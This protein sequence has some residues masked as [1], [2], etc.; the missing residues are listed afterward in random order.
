MT[1]VE[2]ERMVVRLVGDGSSYQKMIDEAINSTKDANRIMGENL[3][4]MQ[5]SLNSLGN[6]VGNIAGQFK[7]FQMLQS[8]FSFVREGVGLAADAEKNAAAFG[9]MFQSME[10]GLK[11]QSEITKFAAETPLNTAGIQ[12]AA[13]MLLQFNAATEDTVIPTLRMLGDVAGGDQQRL[14]GLAL[15]YGQASSTGRLMGQDLLQ[16][17]N[18]GFNPLQE[19]SR[20]TGKS[21]A[22]LKEDMEKGRITVDMLRNAFKT[23]TSE[24]GRFK[25]GMKEASK[26][27]DG[28]VSTMGD[29]L[30]GLKRTVGAFIIESFHLK[31]GIKMVS[32]E[33]Q[34]LTNWFNHLNPVVKEAGVIAGVAALSVGSLV[35]AW[36]IGAA[37]MAMSVGTFQ[38]VKAGIWGV[39]DGVKWLT[40]VMRGQT[41][42]QVQA[43]AGLAEMAGVQYNASAAMAQATTRAR[44]LNG[45]MIGL[46]GTLIALAAYAVIK[47]ASITPMEQR[48]VREM[49]EQLERVRKSMAGMNA[50]YA[51]DRAGAMSDLND[52]K[53]P[54]ERK[55]KLEEMIATGESNINSGR[56]EQDF[57]QNKVNEYRDSIMSSLSSLVPVET[58]WENE[59]KQWEERL[60]GSQQYIDDETEHVRKLKE[61]LEKLKNPAT[62]PETLKALKEYTAELEK[63]A[64]TIGMSKEEIE[65]WKLQQ[66]GATEEQLRQIKAL[67]AFNKEAQDAKDREE[68][69]SKAASEWQDKIDE[70]T[71]SLQEEADTI[72]MT[73]DEAKLYKM[74]LQGLTGYQLDYVKQL[75]E[76]KRTAEAHN[77][78]LEEGKTL[79]EKYMTPL[80]KFSKEAADLDNLMKEGAISRETYDRA[81]ADASKTL[82]DT[83]KNAREA[84]QEVERLDGILANSAEAKA[85]VAAFTERNAKP[86]PTAETFATQERMARNGVGDLVSP[87]GAKNASQEVI[88]KEI[89]D[90]LKAQKDKQVLVKSANL[91]G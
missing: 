80:E 34:N 11:L 84:S 27:F 47:I 29:D 8:P 10:K 32:K 62:N 24:G 7:A 39:I 6:S 87:S 73:S 90:L 44:I 53:D 72:G 12:Q 19:I 65:V 61:E 76:S 45:A 36:K 14:M 60:K 17:I 33:A 43:T 56:Q 48:R 57:N 55:K 42:A 20:T 89:R 81:M 54:A 88:L 1:E 66:M 38:S 3:K 64:A 31:D 51:S 41:V 46:K 23:A 9:G 50:G 86:N 2:L 15:A 70:L 85:R 22:E 21:M 37:A 68:E 18:A 82:E 5:L 49:A 71:S 30:D 79:T 58:A 78:A 69:A 13:K 75:M 4:G 91:N 83:A 52:V 16:M 26:T 28:L 77:K 59:Q 35:V 63:Q 74:Q 67:Q 40:V 25:D